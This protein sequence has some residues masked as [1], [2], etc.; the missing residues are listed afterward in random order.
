MR[1]KKTRIKR[2]LDKTDVDDKLINTAKRIKKE[3][4]KNISNFF[5]CWFSFYH[6]SLHK[7]FFT[8]SY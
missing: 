2:L 6:C 3:Y 8:I 5:E 7:R 1:G 4:K